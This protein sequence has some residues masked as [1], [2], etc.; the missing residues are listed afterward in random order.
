MESIIGI[1]GTVVGLVVVALIFGGAWWLVQRARRGNQA[2]RERRHDPHA[3]VH[4]THT[5]EHDSRRDV[6][7]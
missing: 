5:H 7:Q 4:R 2:V 3:D 6:P 1:T